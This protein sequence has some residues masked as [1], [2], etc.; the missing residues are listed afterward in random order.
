[1][2]K[3]KD[4]HC[5]NC[6]A[7]ISVDEEGGE[8]HRSAPMAQ[9]DGAMRNIKEVQTSWPYVLSDEWCAQYIK[10]EPVEEEEE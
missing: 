7:Y 2:A 8:C 10:G 3:S 4:E 6:G 5:G 9:M 1:M